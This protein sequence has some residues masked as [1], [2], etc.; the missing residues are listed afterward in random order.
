MP[1][2]RHRIQYDYFQHGIV[3]K[4]LDYNWVVTVANTPAPYR[5]GQLEKLFGFPL[6]GLED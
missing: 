6:V 2:E 1:A 3:M 4:H 5:A